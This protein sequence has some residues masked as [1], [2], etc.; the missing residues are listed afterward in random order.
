MLA[1]EARPRAATAE[2]AE[3]ADTN[4][5]PID[6]LA[7]TIADGPGAGDPDT[8]QAVEGAPS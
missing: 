2:A 1:G 8:I 6:L 4:A 3:A 5:D 7:P